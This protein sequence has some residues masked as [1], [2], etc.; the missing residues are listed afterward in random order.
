[1]PIELKAAMFGAAAAL[2]GAVVGG[3]F[4][5]R[6]TRLLIASERERTREQMYGEAK[7]RRDEQWRTELRQALAELL[8]VT[9]PDSGR[10]IAK[11]RIARHTHAVGLLL[12]G[13]VRDQSELRDAVN[14]LSMYVTGSDGMLGLPPD[15]RRLL[16]M[17]N[18]VYQAARA[19]LNRSDS[20]KS[21]G[22]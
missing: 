22:R 15:E 3:L 17:Q 21:D 18:D 11:D 10:G 16:A 20:E 12:N 2:L 1:M 6:T 4:Q 13:S 9:D 5:L 7:L 14:S 19:I 8:A